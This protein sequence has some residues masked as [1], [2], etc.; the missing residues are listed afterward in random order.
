MYMYAHRLLACRPYVYAR[1]TSATNLKSLVEYGSY[2]NMTGP[3]G[4]QGSKKV[5]FKYLTGPWLKMLLKN[6]YKY[7][8][9]YAGGHLG[10]GLSNTVWV[11]GGCRIVNPCTDTVE[12]YD[13]R[14]HH[15]VICKWLQEG[16]SV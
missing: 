8:H 5:E 15:W 13:E 6:D 9:L 3:V 1:R 16:L 4:T 10:T 12:Y 2:E 7:I 11:F 14:D